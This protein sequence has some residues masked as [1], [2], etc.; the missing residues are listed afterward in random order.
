MIAEIDRE[1]YQEVRKFIREHREEDGILPQLEKKF[2]AKLAEL[3][4]RIAESIMRGEFSLDQLYKASLFED[5][6][7]RIELVGEDTGQVE[8][9]GGD[10]GGSDS[11]EHPTNI[12]TEDE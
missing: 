10:K 3:F 9:D 8:N 4:Y 6:R 2:G 11:G 12:R 5:G 1:K 7:V